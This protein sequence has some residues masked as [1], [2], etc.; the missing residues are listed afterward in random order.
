MNGI[1]SGADRSKAAL[2]RCF[3]PHAPDRN[4][5]CKSFQLMLAPMGSRSNILRR[6][7]VLPRYEDSVG[8]S[9]RLKSRRKIGNFA[10]NSALLRGAS[11]D[12]FAGHDET[13]GDADSLLKPRPVFAHDAADFRQSLS[14]ASKSNHRAWE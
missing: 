8:R 3:A 14:L 2:D 11:S 9:E 12:D 4:R 13:G 7:A 5:A 10:G 6:D 1:A